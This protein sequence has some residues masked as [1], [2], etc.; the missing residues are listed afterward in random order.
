MNIKFI[1]IVFIGVVAIILGVRGT[2]KD[3][4]DTLT[5]GQSVAQTSGTQTPQDPTRG[6]TSAVANTVIPSAKTVTV[7]MPQ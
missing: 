3:V 1:I 6:T 5:G 2:Y 7:K 4:W